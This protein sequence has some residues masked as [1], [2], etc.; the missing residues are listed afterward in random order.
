LYVWG[1]NGSGQLGLGDLNNRLVP[2]L[3][4]LDNVVSAQ[5]GASHSI[6]LT[7]DNEVYTSGNNSFGQLGTGNTSDTLNPVLVDVP[8]AVSISAGQYTSLVLRSDA[9][10]FAFGNNV[11]EQLSTLPTSVLSPTHLTSL[12][13]VT[14]IDA[15]AFSSHFLYG[16]EQECAS[17]TVT[18]TVNPTPVVTISE[19]NGVL[20][21][22]PAVPGA[23]YQWYLNGNPIV[24][25]N[26]TDPSIPITAGGEYTVEVTSTDGCFGT[27]AYTSTLDIKDLT[28]SDVYLFPNPAQDVI[29][30]NF[31]T[32]TAATQIVVT[33]QT[34][35]IVI[36]V[37]A[38]GSQTILDIANLATGVYNVS[39]TGE[40][41]Q[42]TLR[43]VKSQQ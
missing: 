43:F 22:V 2:T 38:S 23:T 41:Q 31:G 40:D 10:V 18:V 4:N 24:A 9:S 35:R 33:D 3:A 19:S 32:A 30:V 17:A 1:N 25:P 16:L 7:T 15:S 20:T 37:T 36:D 11:E 26:P 6:F 28:V 21:A 29:T 12:D 27:A 13:G 5:G 14:Y 39:L 42:N 8:S 34:G